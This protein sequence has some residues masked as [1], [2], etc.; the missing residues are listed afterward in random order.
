MA[1]ATLAYDMAMVDR[2]K[3]AALV[4]PRFQTNS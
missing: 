2:N 1:M 4:S 3:A